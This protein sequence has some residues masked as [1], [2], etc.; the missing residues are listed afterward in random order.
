MS[1]AGV[2]FSLTSD[3]D[4]ISGGDVMTGAVVLRDSTK[5]DLPVLFEFQRDP[6]SVRM[7]AFTSAN[8][9]DKE[10][11]L[12]KSSRIIDSDECTMKTILVDGEIAGSAGSFVME[13]DQEVTYWLGREYWG[14]GIATQALAE[15]L[16]EVKV[17]PIFGRTAE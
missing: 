17:R 16:R 14:R 6:E 13:G 11:Y 8:P 12:G 3:G 15:L 9:D 7:A 4:W 2:P 1:G 10:A 5:E